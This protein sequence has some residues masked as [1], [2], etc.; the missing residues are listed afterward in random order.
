M[1]AE[2][3]VAASR[4]V[5]EEAWNQGNL[6]VI[7]QL[8]APDCVEHDLSTHEEIRGI[9]AEKERVRAYRAAMPDLRVSIDDVFA[10]GD[11]VVLRWTARGTNDG[12]L[13]GNQPTHR[14]VEITGISIDRYNAEGKLVEVWDEW[15]NLGFMHQLGMRPQLAARA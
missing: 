14:R 13:M 10:S 12:E 6:A 1:S 15:D 3:N 11:E 9:E 8:C 5:I 2:Q 4:R 7:D